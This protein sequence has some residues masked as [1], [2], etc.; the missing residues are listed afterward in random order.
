LGL[1]NPGLHSRPG[2]KNKKNFSPVHQRPRTKTNNSI[3]SQTQTRKEIPRLKTGARISFKYKE[4]TPHH[5]IPQIPTFYIKIQKKTHPNKSS[6]KHVKNTNPS[7]PA[8]RPKRANQP[9][10]I[11]RVYA[12]PSIATA[13]ASASRKFYPIA[14][15]VFR[16]GFRGRTP[17]SVRS[18][19]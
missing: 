1:Q 19:S 16:R 10:K 9:N 5:L 4:S 7:F 8:A 12:T 13:T 2:K 6:N 15:A 11:L 18:L 17:Y 3:T 14:V